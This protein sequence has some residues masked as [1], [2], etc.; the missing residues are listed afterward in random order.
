MV[1]TLAK[2]TYCLVLLLLLPRSGGAQE[3]TQQLAPADLAV[4]AAGA[5]PASSGDDVVEKWFKEHVKG[6]LKFKN[7]MSFQ[8][9]I[10]EQT[11]I[12]Q[13]GVLRLDI[14]QDLNENFRLFLAP[15]WKAD[16][17]NYVKAPWMNFRDSTSRDP[18]FSFHQGYLRYKE[19]SFDVTVGKQI[20]SWG[21]ADG[22]N[23]TDYLLNPWD[24]QD[25]PDREKIGTFSISAN[26]YL[27]DTSFQFIVIPLFTPSRIPMTNNR[28]LGIPNLSL[29]GVP[30]G[31]LGLPLVDFLIR[32]RRKLPPARFENT[33]VAFRAKTS[34]ITGWDLSLSYFDGFDNLPLVSA[35]GPICIAP[36]I[37][38][39]IPK[40]MFSRVRA[41]GFDF[42]TTFGKLEVHGEAQAR[43]Y[44]GGRT[45]DRLPL[46]F[47][48]RYVWDQAD[49]AG[50]GLE[51]ILFVLEYGHDIDLHKRDNIL[52]RDLSFFV[53]PIQSQIMS[54]I[55]L[56]IDD[57]NEFNFS[58]AINFY[59]PNSG[60]LQPK[61]TYKFTD[62]LK[63]DIG[64]DVF[65]GKF[66]VDP[67][68][69]P[70][71]VKTKLSFW[72]KWDRNDRGF[73]N[74]TYLF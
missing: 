38:V 71:S 8:T 69:I 54:R 40:T 74:L 15:Q 7:F 26:Y 72:G 58:T 67:I 68:L 18:Y 41:P 49:L 47:G 28:W 12:R 43:F 22:Y 14:T 6:T 73:L 36:G 9:T 64:F 19:E 35:E 66:S 37:C 32:T 13:E 24:Y 42:S 4:T 59:G 17:R 2:I 27:P 65:W 1:K 39:G 45:T 60:Y 16:T 50:T 34:A 21:T 53:R 25:I 51:Q 52:T 55:G 56:K 23:P 44:D 63:A 20:Y 48:G 46:V 70:P 3:P 33:Q 29:F 10:E 61:Y 62:N 11:S 31:K 5:A 30:L 57:A